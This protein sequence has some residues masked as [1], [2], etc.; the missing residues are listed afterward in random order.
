MKKKAILISI[1][2]LGLLLGGIGLV[3]SLPQKKVLS[4]VVCSIEGDIKEFSLNVTIYRRFFRIKN[5]VGTIETGGKKYGTVGFFVSN[6]VPFYD[7][8][9]KGFV[10]AT[11]INNHD[12]IYFTYYDTG[13]SSVSIEFLQ[14]F[15]DAPSVNTLY[16]GPANTKE[17]AEEIFHLYY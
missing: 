1:V 11:D 16:F 17:K 5:I 14:R 7:M 6:Y 10:D 12:C 4:Y 9:E 15:S 3:S 13:L 8:T 2:L